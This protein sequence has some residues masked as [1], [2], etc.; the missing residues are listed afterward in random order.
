MTEIPTTDL[1]D[2]HPADLSQCQLQFRDFGKKKGFHGRIRTVVTMHDTKLA[3]QLFKEPGDGQ[4][5]V[6]DSGGS[7]KT[8]ML[9]D[10]QADIL[11][12]NGWA[13]IIINGAIRDSAELAKVDL[14]VKAL[15]V[16]S[17]RSGKA[18]VGAIDVPIAFGELLFTPGDYVYCDEDAVLLSKKA[19]DELTHD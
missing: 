16:T 3:Q 1:H 10:I 7:L 11:R 2:A 14:G 15:G 18:G 9:G 12:Q 17:I 19:P 13:G 8:A 4:V 6:I 5:A